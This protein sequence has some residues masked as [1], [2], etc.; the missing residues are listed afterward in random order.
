MTALFRAE[1]T[2][3]ADRQ[4]CIRIRIASAEVHRLWTTKSFA[5][6]FL[7]EPIF[8]G[9]AALPEALGAVIPQG[10]IDDFD[11]RVLAKR[12]AKVVTTCEIESVEPIGIRQHRALLE[13]MS[14]EEIAAYLGDFSRAPC[15]VLR[16]R[17]KDA[18]MIAH[19]SVGM[20][21]DSCACDMI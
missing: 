13:A 17:V 19:L 1:V 20:S 12:A 16:I 8:F 10:E 15:A 4:I 14:S 21:W 18:R 5:L 6:S 3:V 9:Q 2:E 7:L 11:T